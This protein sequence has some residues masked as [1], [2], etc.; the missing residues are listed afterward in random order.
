MHTRH[1][2]GKQNLVSDHCQ[3]RKNEE[4][5]TTCC[6]PAWALTASARSR[7]AGVTGSDRGLSLSDDDRGSQLRLS[8]QGNQPGDRRGVGPTREG[9]QGPS[10]RSAKLPV[11]QQTWTREPRLP[12]GTVGVACSAAH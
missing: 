6:L 9:R 7:E 8:G 12:A 1:W 11:G 10:G 3:I 5:N 2:G 4:R